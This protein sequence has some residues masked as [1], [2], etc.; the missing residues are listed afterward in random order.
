MTSEYQDTLPPQPTQAPQA[1]MAPQP[2]PPSAPSATFSISAA[3]FTW[4][5]ASIVMIAG[6]LITI[7][8]YFLPWATISGTVL[9]QS[10]GAS[11]AG[12]DFLVVLLGLATAAGG[13]AFAYSKPRFNIAWMA[14]AVL[15]AAILLLML[16]YFA[17]YNNATSALGS[18][19][20]LVSIGLGIGFFISVIGALV[21][22]GGAYLGRMESLGRRI[23]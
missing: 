2:A 11:V 20:G 17:D 9:G 6:G 4:S 13:A 16:K 23:M 7:V 18:L 3:D 19:G 21:V 1:P 15:G 14:V 12:S 5:L 22:L 8:G 10:L